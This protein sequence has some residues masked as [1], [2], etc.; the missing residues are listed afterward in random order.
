MENF[1]FC[2]VKSNKLQYQ[3][4]LK[5]LSPYL[6]IDKKFSTISSSVID[7]KIALPP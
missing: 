6:T 3:L 7:A 2:A 1:I 4:K 5:Y